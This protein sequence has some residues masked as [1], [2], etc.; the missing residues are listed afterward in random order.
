MDR[1]YN[2]NIKTKLLTK[3]AYLETHH[4]PNLNPVKRSMAEPN[5]SLD[6]IEAFFHNSMKESQDSTSLFLKNKVDGFYLDEKEI[7]NFTFESEDNNKKIEQNINIKALQEENKR[8]K[9]GFIEKEKAYL[10]E[11]EM[12]SKE[13]MEIKD[14]YKKFEANI[15]QIVEEKNLF[16]EKLKAEIKRKNEDPMPSF[17][18][19]Q[20][21]NKRK[22]LEKIIERLESDNKQLILEKQELEANFLLKTLENERLLNESGN[23]RLWKKKY[24]DLE[25]SHLKEIEDFKQNIENLKGKRMEL[26]V[27]EKVAEITH[28]K[29]QEIYKLRLELKESLDRNENLSKELNKIR[30]SMMRGSKE[31]IVVLKEINL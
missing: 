15:E 14:K 20:K 10:R 13:I 28:Q 29:S 1:S 27:S 25:T 4:F 3:N 19:F 8:L 2:F 22:D 18:T 6:K 5:P 12:I 23:S 16:I 30:N 9:D 24:E 11:I 26:E 21:E 7:K 31:N 17:K